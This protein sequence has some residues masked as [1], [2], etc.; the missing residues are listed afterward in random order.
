MSEKQKLRIGA[1]SAAVSFA[2]VLI[3]MTPLAFLPHSSDS[4]VR[5]FAIGWCIVLIPAWLIKRHR[6][7][8]DQL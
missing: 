8:K 6:A 7:F 3:Q 4:F 1:I 5:G 2:V